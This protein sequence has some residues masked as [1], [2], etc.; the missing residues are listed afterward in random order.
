[1]GPSLDLS[2]ARNGLSFGR[3]R[4][5]INQYDRAPTGSPKSA[6]AI[7]VDFY[8]ILDIAGMADIEV[9]IGTAKDVDE[10]ALR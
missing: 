5:V 2:L 3:L 1:M 6:P 8:T 10:K 4:L 7:I 9:A